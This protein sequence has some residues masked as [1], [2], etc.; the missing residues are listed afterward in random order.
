MSHNHIAFTAEEPH[1]LL[2][3]SGKVRTDK[4]GTGY[5][6]H[7]F[8]TGKYGVREAKIDQPK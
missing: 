8:G 4:I 2:T 1:Y 5:T 3:Q 7:D 6:V